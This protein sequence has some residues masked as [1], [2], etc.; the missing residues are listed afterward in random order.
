MKEA[1]YYTC[2]LEVLSFCDRERPSLTLFNKNKRFNFSS[3]Q[4][5]MKPSAALFI[6]LIL[7]KSTLVTSEDKRVKFHLNLVLLRINQVEVPRIVTE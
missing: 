2:R 6:F 4:S 7:R 3:E 5:K 1:S